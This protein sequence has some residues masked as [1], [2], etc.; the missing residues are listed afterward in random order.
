MD[1]QPIEQ[2]PEAPCSV[3]YWRGGAWGR[4]P[5]LPPEC[6]MGA[7]GRDERFDLGFWDGQGW[8]DMGTGHETFAEYIDARF[9]PTHWKPLTPP[10]PEHQHTHH[11]SA[12]Q[13]GKV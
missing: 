8:C 13:E 4:E 11:K 7:E 5:Q 12:P 6:R 9:Y 1:W 10:R 2:E 3:L